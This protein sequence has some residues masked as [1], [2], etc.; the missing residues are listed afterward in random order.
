MTLK[1]NT[2]GGWADIATTLKRYSGGW[3]DV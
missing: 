3:L 2:G 1:R